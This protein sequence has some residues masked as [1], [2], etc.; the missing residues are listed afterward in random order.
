MVL[1]VDD[2]IPDEVIERLEAE[3]GLSDIRFIVLERQ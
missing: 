2:P 3:P 1:S